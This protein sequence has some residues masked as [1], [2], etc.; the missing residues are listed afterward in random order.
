MLNMW[1]N[2]TSDDSTHL[3]GYLWAFLAEVADVA[4]KK[5]SFLLYPVQFTDLQNQSA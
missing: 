1:V 4:E 5:Q 2:E 3:L